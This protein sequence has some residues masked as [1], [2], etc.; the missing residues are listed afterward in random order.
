MG[1]AL[2]NKFLTLDY[3]NDVD[4]EGSAQYSDV[5]LNK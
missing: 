5:I 1:L 2:P 3:V 4:R